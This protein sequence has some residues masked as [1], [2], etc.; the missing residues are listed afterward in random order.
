MSTLHPKVD[1][2]I[3]V[4]GVVVDVQRQ[5]ELDALSDVRSLEK[6]QTVGVQLPPDCSKTGMS[7]NFKN[8]KTLS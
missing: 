5:S 6:S 2:H 3:A 8:G 4:E 1:L 7:S